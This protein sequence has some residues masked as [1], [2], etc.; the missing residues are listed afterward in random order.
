MGYIRRI[1]TAHRKQIKNSTVDN[2]RAKKESERSQFW[3][4]D[5][6][7]FWPKKSLSTTSKLPKSRLTP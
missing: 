1:S 5:R 3:Q 6:S 4:S 2:P 7:Q